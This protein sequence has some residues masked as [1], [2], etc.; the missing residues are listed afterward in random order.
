MH[1]RIKNW[2]DRLQKGAA[3][4]R[5]GVRGVWGIENW[6]QS[7]A[8]HATLQASSSPASKSPEISPEPLRQIIVINN[9]SPPWSHPTHL[10]GGKQ[11]GWDPVAL[12]TE[13]W[14]ACPAADRLFPTL[15][16]CL[17]V[18]SKTPETTAAGRVI[19]TVLGLKGVGKNKKPTITCDL[20]HPGV[21][22]GWCIWLSE[23]S[24]TVSGL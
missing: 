17:F 12:V 3:G 5:V 4:I 18:Y 14:P 1:P 16:V 10:P 19:F 6:A 15:F 24:W 9:K 7:P 21:L 2:E 20:V 23:I 8:Q 11:T 22:W 13:P